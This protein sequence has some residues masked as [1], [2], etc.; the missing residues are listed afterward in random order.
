MRYFRL[1]FAAPLAVLVLAAVPAA[2]SA[3]AVHKKQAPADGTAKKKV[4]PKTAFFD[5]E[6]PI[7][8]TLSIN[9]K[10]IRGDK[11]DD[12]PWRG[13]T[14]SYADP[15][16]KKID[17][18]IKARTRGIWRLKN[19]EFPPLRLNLP[20]KASIGTVFEGLNKPK[21]VS[22]CRNND[23]FEQYILQEMQI[24]RAYN[25]LTPAS[26]K[27]RLL[28][29]TY[30]D[31]AS[32]K[33]LTTRY[34]IVLEEPEAMAARFNG[35]IIETVGAT[36]DDL[37]PE[38][39]RLVG[40]FQYLIA[41]TD[42]SINGLHNFELVAREDGSVL[43]IAYDFDFAGAINASYASVDPQFNVARVR[44]RLFRGYCAPAEEY[45]KTFSLFRT[46]KDAIYGLYT[47][48][49]GQLMNKKVADETLK[50][51]N[52]FYKTIGDS[53]RAKHEILDSCRR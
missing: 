23:T 45:E 52:D 20:E 41:N 27:A 24:Y 4:H 46:K 13:A 19:C 35:G 40:V 14:L 36:A 31:S 11:G 12:A 26:H 29:M 2:A 51:Y 34:A 21:L 33:T 30:T 9:V 25:I 17:I 49:I 1:R 38:H 43:P 28:R 8:V 37:D 5:S 50:F 44:D 6:D 42:F 32:G 15:S 16:G 18:P 48:K 53:R 47:D 22:Y 7:D 10:R 39:A 3:Q